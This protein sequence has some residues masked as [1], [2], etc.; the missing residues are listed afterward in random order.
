MITR[1]QNGLVF[2]WISVWKLL[3]N[4][5]NSGS[6]VNYRN[7]QQNQTTISKAQNH[8]KN[9]KK[10]KKFLLNHV[11]KHKTDVRKIKNNI[12]K[13]F[14]INKNEFL[15]IRQ[16]P[17]GSRTRSTAHSVETFAT[18]NSSERHSLRRKQYSNYT[19][20]VKTAIQRTQNQNT[21]LTIYWENEK[22]H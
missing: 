13:S 1:R 15:K 2:V 12:Q 22:R 19:L 16:K 7:Q 18:K 9:F 6:N 5:S 11:S 14:N 17:F 20:K 21:M 8:L 3:E 4:R 10:Y